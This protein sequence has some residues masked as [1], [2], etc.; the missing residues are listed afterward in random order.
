MKGFML[1]LCTV[2][3]LYGFK[4][5]PNG[6]LFLLDCIKLPNFDGSNDISPNS[7]G[8]WPRLQKGW[9]IPVMYS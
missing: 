1:Q 2:N 3:F 7:T 8:P 5:I 4:S 9:K 6:S